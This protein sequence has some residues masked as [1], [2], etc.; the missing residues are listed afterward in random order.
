MR[1]NFIK[2]RVLISIALTA[3][4]LALSHRYWLIIRHLPDRTS[5]KFEFLIFI[6]LL[7]LIYLFV[8]KLTDYMANFKTIK[9]KSRIDIIFLSIFFVFLFIPMSHINQDKVSQQENRTLAEW[10]PFILQKGVVNYNFGND[11]NAYFSDRFALRKP[12]VT[13]YK[14]LKMALSYKF[15]EENGIYYNKRTGW[16]YMQTWFNVPD[17]TSKMPD[18]TESIQKLYDF[19]HKNGIKLYIVVAPVKEEV[20]TGEIEPFILRQNNGKIF[21]EGINKNVADI[22]YFPLDE[23]KEASKNDFTYPKSDPHWGEYGGYIAANGFLK[24]FGFKTLSNNDFEIKDQVLP[25]ITDYLEIITPDFSGHYYRSFKIENKQ[26]Y[27]VFIH[28]NEKK[29]ITSYIDNKLLYKNTHFPLAKNPQKV[30][31]IGTSFSENFWY[32]LRFAFKDVIKRR[33]NNFVFAGKTIDFKER[34]YDEILKEKPDILILC[35]ESNYL[36]RYNSMWNK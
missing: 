19:C 35:T 4:G 7:V 11:F 30:Y 28:K 9:G 23:L 12:M 20:Y 14:K 2:K 31:L 24:H 36:D 3:A 25:V 15:I 1:F 21:T 26:P 18:I 10:K 34:Y 5:V 16:A 33:N 22:V 29:L 8:Y 17:I 27:K 6:I 13:L 32:F